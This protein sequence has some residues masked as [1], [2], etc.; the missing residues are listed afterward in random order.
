MDMAFC[1]NISS[2]NIKLKIFFK[3]I[4]IV[5]KGID[6]MQKN[7]MKKNRLRFLG[8]LLFVLMFFLVF[9]CGDVSANWN[10][11]ELTNYGLPSGSVYNIIREILNWLLGVLGFIGVISFAI[12][13]IMYLVSAGNDDMTKKAKNAMKFSIIGVIVALSGVVAIQAVDQILNA[14]ALW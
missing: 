2:I 12:S 6:K 10:A 4:K 1:V 13:G 14:N 7:K 11:D 8:T 9:G 5:L 3:A